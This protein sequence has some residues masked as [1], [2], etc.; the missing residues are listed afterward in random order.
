[1][2]YQSPHYTAPTSGTQLTKTITVPSTIFTGV[3]DIKV[4][5]QE[6][7]TGGTSIEETLALAAVL[8][9]LKQV[10]KTVELFKKQNNVKSTT[11]TVSDPTHQTYDNPTNNI[12]SGWG[13][14]NK[15]LLKLDVVFYGEK[16]FYNRWSFSSRC[17]LVTP[18]IIA[19][20]P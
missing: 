12:P 11:F 20:R 4:E 13:Q 5:V 19:R 1:M 2:V 18:V 10:Q 16:N 14:L 17:K 15:I 9:A 8:A 6:G 7:A 3:K